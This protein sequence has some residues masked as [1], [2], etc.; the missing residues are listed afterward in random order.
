MGV[1]DE[2]IR[3]HLELRRRNGA[4]DQEIAVKRAEALGPARRDAADEGEPDADESPAFDQAP[5]RLEEPSLAGSSE[6]EEPAPSASLE[7]S[8]LPEE[9]AAPESAPALEGDLFDEPAAS[10]SGSLDES[11]PDLSPETEREPRGAY[12]AAKLESPVTEDEPEPDLALADERLDI[13]MP[14][15]IEQEDTDASA[16]SDREPATEDDPSPPSA[17]RSGPPPWRSLDGPAERRSPPGRAAPG[18]PE[19]L[20]DSADDVLEET[21][22]FLQET[23]EHERLWFEQRPPRDFDFDD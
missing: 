22:D 8:R 1:L 2:A 5:E 18:A 4:S 20:P 17:Q 15:A 21:P 13:D 16:V 7:A 12:P 9:P 3:E 23:P 6:S 14:A 11:E 10:G 19:P